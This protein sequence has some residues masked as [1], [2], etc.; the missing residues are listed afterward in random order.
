MPRSPRS[1]KVAVE[2]GGALGKDPQDTSPHSEDEDDEDEI[3]ETSENGRWQKIDE[4]VSIA[5]ET[6]QRTRA[7]HKVEDT[8]R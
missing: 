2:P 6:T 3:L 7:E 5:I 4:H 8:N 1:S